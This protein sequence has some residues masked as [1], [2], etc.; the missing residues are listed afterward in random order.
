[1]VRLKQHYVSQIKEVQKCLNST[2]VRLKL[3][4]GIY[5]EV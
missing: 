3:Q 5:S 2:M 4:G 1:M